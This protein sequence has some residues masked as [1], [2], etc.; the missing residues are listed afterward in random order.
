MTKEKWKFLGV[1]F[2]MAIVLALLMTV[3]YL[4]WQKWSNEEE[5]LRNVVGLLNYNLQT[6]HLVG[7]PAAPPPAPA[8]A[9]APT[10]TPVPTPP[11]E[12]PAKK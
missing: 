1:S 5:T 12:A 3:G 10:A 9:P 8:A 2:G 7:P 4:K 6:G 11:A